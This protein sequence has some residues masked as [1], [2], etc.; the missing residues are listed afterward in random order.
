MFKAEH[1]AGMEKYRTHFST[2]FFSSDRGR[3]FK[4]YPE[5]IAFQ[6]VHPK[7]KAGHID[8]S[9]I[10][11]QVAAGYSCQWVQDTEITTDYG[12]RGGLLGETGLENG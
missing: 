1:R 9:K 10:A 11:A 6:Q 7:W 12:I 8:V 3:H 5:V 2:I 4:A